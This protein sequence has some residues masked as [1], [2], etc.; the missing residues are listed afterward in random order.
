MASKTTA[1]S[2]AA[3]APLPAIDK[4]QRYTVEESLRYLRTSRA[5]FYAA[6]KQR[7]INLIKEGRRSYV[8]GAQIA[9][10]SCVPDES[11][12]A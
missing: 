10:L 3:P 2:G 8:S 5:S 12:A 1:A 9:K 4:V 7:R 11:A 6:V